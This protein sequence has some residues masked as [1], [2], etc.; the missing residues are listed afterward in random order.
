VTALKILLLEKR[1]VDLL[2]SIHN[3][4]L[5]ID[6]EGKIIACNKTG[7][8]LLGKTKLASFLRQTKGK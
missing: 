4:V 5:I 3:G 1:V 6:T 8:E 7:R 2:D